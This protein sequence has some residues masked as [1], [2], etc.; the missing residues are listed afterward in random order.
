VVVLAYE[1]GYA[2]YSVP[3]GT[4]KKCPAFALRPG[5]GV[6]VNAFL[7]LQPAFAAFTLLFPRTRSLTP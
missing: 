5:P 4:L 2:V 6:P 1:D 7:R 3:L